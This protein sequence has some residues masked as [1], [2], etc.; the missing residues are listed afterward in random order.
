MKKAATPRNGQ[1][2]DGFIC[3]SLLNFSDNSLKWP[4]AAALPRIHCETT[5]TNALLSL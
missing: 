3:D 4:P 1:E 5:K 2:F